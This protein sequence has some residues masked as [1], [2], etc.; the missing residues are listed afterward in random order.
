MHKTLRI[1]FNR[2]F[3]PFAHGD[4][5]QCSGIV[6]DIVKRAMAMAAYSVE[7]VP[8]SLDNLA[9]QFADGEIHAFAGIAITLDRQ[10]QVVFSTP[11]VE[12]G[13][14]WF[15][16]RNAEA[17]MTAIAT[18]SAGPLVTAVQSQF[19]NINIRGVADY[20]SALELTISG[21]VDA[22]ALNIHVGADMAQR[23]FPNEF[24]L[25]DRPFCQLHLGLAFARETEARIINSF[26]AAV[27]FLRQDGSIDAIASEH[28]PR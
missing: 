6:I 23:Y 25:P 16:L 3:Y 8:R 10:L 5:E 12:S 19:P 18:P 28:R 14:A 22:A 13:G 2:D 17:P 20:R 11:L 26:D 1:G 27:G 15:R 24:L 7:F 9:R 4:S 21:E